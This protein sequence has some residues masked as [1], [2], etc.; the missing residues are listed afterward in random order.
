MRVYRCTSST[1]RGTLKKQTEFDPCGFLIQ[2]NL[3]PF[4]N[5]RKRRTGVSS[6]LRKRKPIGFRA[7][8]EFPLA[9]YRLPPR[10]IGAGAFSGRKQCQNFP[11]KCVPERYHFEIFIFVP[12][13]PPFEKNPRSATEFLR[14]LTGRFRAFSCV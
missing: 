3:P 6:E 2:E 1:R 10:R 12:P 9:S 8:E 4:C 7:C 5:L 14:N 11:P 13:N